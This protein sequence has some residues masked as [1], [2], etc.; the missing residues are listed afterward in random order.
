[1]GGKGLSLARESYLHWAVE[2]SCWPGASFILNFGF[3]IVSLSLAER[4][5][6]CPFCLAGEDVESILRTF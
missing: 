1:M 4:G 3:E 5:S 6:N 2:G